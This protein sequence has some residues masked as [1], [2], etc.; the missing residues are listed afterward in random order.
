M[1]FPSQTDSFN[2]GVMSKV[3]A[4]AKTGLAFT[5]TDCQNQKLE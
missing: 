3:G 5:A 1:L 2:R 4:G